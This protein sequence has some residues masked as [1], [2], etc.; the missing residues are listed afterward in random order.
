MFVTKGATTKYLLEMTATHTK[1]KY[2]RTEIDRAIN[3]L[4]ELIKK[5][6]LRAVVEVSGGVAEVTT[7]PDGVEVQIIDHD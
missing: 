7:S 4:Y 1:K 3:D 6:P 5:Q 2:A